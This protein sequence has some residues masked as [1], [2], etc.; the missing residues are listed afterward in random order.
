MHFSH[1]TKR[2]LFLGLV[3][4]AI[5]F[6]ASAQVQD[7]KLAEEYY[8]QGDFEKASVLYEKLFKEQ[9]NSSYYFK[10]YYECLVNLQQYE[11]LEKVLK[12]QLRKFP[13]KL[14]YH[15]DLGYLYARLEQDDKAKA[16]YDMALEEL[17]AE[18]GQVVQLANAFSNINEFEYAI[19][20]FE[21]GKSLLKGKDAFNSELAN[22]YF[23][24][25][26]IPATIE[27]YLDYL[28]KAPGT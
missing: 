7:Q 20:V 24:K 21:K 8:K 28:G 13:N 27:S 12:K 5:S 26:N 19:Q 17:S 18:R 25:G 2:A 9:P 4:F 22:L 6:A 16:E 11:E 10:Y 23:K 3:S 14:Q 1:Y 15:V